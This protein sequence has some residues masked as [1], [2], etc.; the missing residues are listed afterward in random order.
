MMNYEIGKWYRVPA[1]RVAEWRGFRGWLPVIGPKHEDAELIG[2]KPWHWHLNL[3]FVPKRAYWD[4]FYSSAYAVPI[5]CPD[6]NGKQVVMDGPLL[7]RMKCVREWPP[8]PLDKIKGP[9]GWLPK[10]EAAY[11]SCKLK[12]GMV[13]PHRGI[14]LASVPA[15]D[16]IVTCPGHGLRW[17]IETGELVSLPPTAGTGG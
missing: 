10:L 12:P 16:G 8:Y 4:V 15:V 14:P 11:S 6:N 7:R 5:S 13:C 1:V 17:N 9:R 2:F 3:P